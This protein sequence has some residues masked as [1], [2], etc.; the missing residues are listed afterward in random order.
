MATP[1]HIHSGEVAVVSVFEDRVEKRFIG[2]NMVYEGMYEA[3][4]EGLRRCETYGFVPRIL[5][6][7]TSTKTITMSR[8]GRCDA[9][10]WMLIYGNNRTATA[11]AMQQIALTVRRYILQLHDN[12]L[13]HRDVKLENLTF[14]FEND[15]PYKISHVYLIDFATCTRAKYGTTKVVS[16]SFSSP[17]AKKVLHRLSKRD[18]VWS[19]LACLYV[20][21]SGGHPM[22][23]RYD[24]W[25]GHFMRWYHN[26]DP[27]FWLGVVDFGTLS[28]RAAL[29]FSRAFTALKDLEDEGVLPTE[30]EIENL[31]NDV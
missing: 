28:V 6:N 4:V 31:F 15:D 16:A 29:F 11:R 27:A 30:E 12:G 14:E 3:E 5:A 23:V 20:W 21:V 24:E 8:V 25:E 13:S 7:D 22:F 1:L 26:A 9:L 10:D 17:E 2:K 19:F 18:D